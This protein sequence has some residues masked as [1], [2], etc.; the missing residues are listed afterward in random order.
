M[1]LL[2]SWIDL[3]ELLEVLIHLYFYGVLVAL[4]N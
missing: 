2:P 1:T 4:G 3:Y